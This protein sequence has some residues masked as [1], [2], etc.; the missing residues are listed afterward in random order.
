MLTLNNIT[1]YV[2]KNKNKNI[3]NNK[4]FKNFE[5][6]YF[7][8]IQSVNTIKFFTNNFSFNYAFRFL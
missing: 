2:K 6:K 8:V 5:I 3:E 7:A 1:K 4:S